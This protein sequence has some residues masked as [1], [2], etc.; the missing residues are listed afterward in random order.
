MRHILLDPHVQG[1]EERDGC[2]WVFNS[3]FIELF[4]SY[5]SMFTCIKALCIYIY[6]YVL[7]DM[8]IYIHTYMYV[9]MYVCMHACMHVCMY[10]CM[11]VCMC[12][13]IYIY[14]YIYIYTHAHLSWRML[15]ES[16]YELHFGIIDD[17]S[18]PVTIGLGTTPGC[19]TM[20]LNK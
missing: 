19:R 2:T 12:M 6:I 15:P 10:V 16:G 13:H 11:Y 14:I 18:R 1:Q 3:G 9:C 5:I 4:R 7:Y 17:C 8:C 20:S